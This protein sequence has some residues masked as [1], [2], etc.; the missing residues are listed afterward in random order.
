MARSSSLFM[1]RQSLWLIVLCAMLS[2]GSAYF[3]SW[4]SQQLA[5]ADVTGALASSSLQSSRLLEPPT[6]PVEPRNVL[7]AALIGALIGLGAGFL[8]EHPE[9]II[10]SSVESPHAVPQM[11]LS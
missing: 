3:F 9:N 6:K 10:L 11:R 2:A 4:Q 5:Q 8:M 1:V 7:L